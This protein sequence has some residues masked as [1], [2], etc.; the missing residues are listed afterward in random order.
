[1]TKQGISS[2]TQQNKKLSK[3]YKG[4]ATYVVTNIFFVLCWALAGYGYF[5]PAWAMLGWG[6]ALV[7]QYIKIRS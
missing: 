7:L 6:L 3:F 1:M 4:V 2:E 5:W